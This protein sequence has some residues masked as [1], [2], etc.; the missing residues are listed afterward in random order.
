[1]DCERTTAAGST[2][3]RHEKSLGLLTMKFVALL[4]ETPDG[5]FDLR[6]AADILAVKQKR[7]V[8]DITN[9][10]EG[11]GLIEKITQNIIQ[12]RGENKED[13]EQVRL[14]QDQISELDAQEKELDKQ[15]KWLRQNNV[16]LNRSPDTDN[17]YFVTPEDI[18]N[19]FM[20]D[21]ILLVMPPSGTQL[22]VTLL[23]KT[24]RENY[25]PTLSSLL[26]GRPHLLFEHHRLLILQPGFAQLTPTGGAA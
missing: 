15:M 5:I 7:R 16:R 22:E 4:K 11:V 8:Y 13:L 14:L 2:P 24:G 20:G 23:E 1:M 18:C 10:L 21:T 26:H 12:W 3:P 19:S 6:K 17:Y 25:Q 9:V